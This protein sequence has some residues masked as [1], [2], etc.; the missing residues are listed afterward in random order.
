MITVS[1]ASLKCWFTF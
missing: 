1:F